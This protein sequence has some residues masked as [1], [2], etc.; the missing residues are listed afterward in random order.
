MAHYSILSFGTVDGKQLDKLIP[1]KIDYWVLGNRACPD[2]ILKDKI[3]HPKSL[4]GA[5]VISFKPEFKAIQKQPKE[6]GICCA[7]KTDL[8]LIKTLGCSRMRAVIYKGK[9][10]NIIDSNLDKIL[11]IYKR[12]PS[13]SLIIAV[14]CHE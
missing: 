2:F 13:D 3:K 7:A 11:K 5:E 14:D 6:E 8:N 9:W 4:L 10:I 12:L 1:S